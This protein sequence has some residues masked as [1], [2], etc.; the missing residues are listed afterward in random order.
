MAQQ[1]PSV[2]ERPTDLMLEILAQIAW[3]WPAVFSCNPQGDIWPT[4]TKGL[5]R[6]HQRVQVRG[7]L[8][9]LDT[10]AAFVLRARPEGGRFF[11]DEHGL[12]LSDGDRLILRFT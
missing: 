2:I 9:Y 10:L 6:E 7:R 8:P 3:R 11:I 12:F 4:C 1:N 5:S